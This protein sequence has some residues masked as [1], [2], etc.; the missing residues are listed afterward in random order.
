MKRLLFSSALVFGVLASAQGLKREDVIG[1][2]KLKESGFYEGKNKVVKD[3]DNCQLMRNYAIREDGFAVY[4]YIEGKVGDCIPSEPR[5][6]F[7]KIIDNRIQFY[8]DDKNILEEVVV[9]VNKDK[10]MTFSSYIAV[11]VKDKDPELEKLLN[12][13]HYDIVEFVY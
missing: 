12:T 2:W 5:L 3:F 13:I 11:P 7:W 9:T 8:A 10:T 6:T 1:F 4:N